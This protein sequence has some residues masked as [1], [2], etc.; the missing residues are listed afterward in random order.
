MT[1]VSGCVAERTS[2]YAYLAYAVVMSGIVHPIVAHWVW[3][4]GGWLS[5]RPSGTISPLFGQGAID[6]AGCISV[7]IIGGFA[8]LVG[9]IAVGPRLGR[10]DSDGNVTPMPGHSATLCCLGA[11]ILL[12]GWFG[13]NAGSVESVITTTNTLKLAEINTILAAS[14]AGLTTLFLIRIRDGINDLISVLNGMLAGCVS[15]TSACGIVEP[16]AA[17]VIG[18][19]GAIIYILAAKATL[20]VKV[21]DPLEA[22]PI[23]GCVGFWGSVAAGLFSTK[24]YQL[25][26]GYNVNSWGLFYG[27]G[28]RLLGANV[29]GCLATIAFVSAFMVPFFLIASYLGVLRVSD[30]E[31]IIGLDFDG[32]GGYAYPEEAVVEE[33]EEVVKEEIPLNGKVSQ[34]FET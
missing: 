26:A 16:W 11:M 8:G 29:V 6:I 12:F 10:F 18:I 4:H 2:F 5:A 15:I 32:H 33:E 25:E 7:H 34:Q 30:E 14:S 22:F 23:H 1:I 31:E 28:I 9:A 20:M 17:I 24:T 19:I 3:G 13:F 27:G 21:D